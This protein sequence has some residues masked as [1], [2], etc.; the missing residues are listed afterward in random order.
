MDAEIDVPGADLAEGDLAIRLVPQ[1]AAEFV[2]TN[3]FLVRH[4]S[5]LADEKK[6]ICRDCTG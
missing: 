2:C 4:R 6:I 1:Q 3:C 5:Q